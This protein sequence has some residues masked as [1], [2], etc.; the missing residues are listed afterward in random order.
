MRIKVI[1]LSIITSLFLSS[2]ATSIE[3][4]SLPLTKYPIKSQYKR[5]FA[6]FL[7]NDVGSLTEFIPVSESSE[8]WTSMISLQYM[9]GVK[10]T[11]EEA[12]NN[13][14]KIAET[15][16]G[17]DF[18]HKIIEKKSKSILF[19]WQVLNCE[20]KDF[21]KYIQRGISVNDCNLNYFTGLTW[22]GSKIMKP[23]CNVK[24]TQTE[25]VRLIQGN[26]GLHRVSFTVKSN[27]INSE[28]YSNWVTRF[29]ETT[30]WK[31]KAQIQ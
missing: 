26:D 20:Q 15:Q 2:C 8:N 23:T 28:T 14:T 18:K 4:T 19:E 13:L 16:C 11:A 3:R 29:K 17:K 31:G 10:S 1:L 21:M 6:Q 25:L 30:V 12:F 24:T 7:G 9:Q 27:K 5:D 22:Q